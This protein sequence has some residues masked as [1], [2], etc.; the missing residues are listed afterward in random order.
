MTGNKIRAG[1]LNTTLYMFPLNVAKVPVTFMPHNGNV[2][3]YGYDYTGMH[4][5]SYCSSVLFSTIRSHH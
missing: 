5:F 3:A 4:T 1:L 2:H